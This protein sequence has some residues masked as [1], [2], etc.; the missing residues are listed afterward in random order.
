MNT[1]LRLV[2][3]LDKKSGEPIIEEVQVEP[4]GDHQYRLLRSPGMVPG[5][6][7]GDIFEVA[8]TETP[9]YRLIRRGGN[10]CLQVF[11]PHMPDE[12]RDAIVP[13]IEQLGG[14]LDGQYR[15][16]STSMIVLTVPASAGFPSIEAVMA[17]LEAMSP[18]SEWYY[19]N[20]YDL[21]D[22][23]TPL[24]WWKNPVESDEQ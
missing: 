13:L 16:A 2:A 18:K 21:K 20:V 19:N 22:E 17:K 8:E 6:A 12:C 3:E 7:A 14:R 5:L 1:T 23:R 9:S 15:T 10:I 24:N 4:M 11:F